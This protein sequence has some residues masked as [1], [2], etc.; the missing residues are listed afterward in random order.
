M[1]EHK[2]NEHLK[3]QSDKHFKWTTA[4][5]IITIAINASTAVYQWVTADAK[6][7]NLENKISALE[8]EIEPL[9]D[10][11]DE[12]ENILE[13]IDKSERDFNEVSESKFIATEELE[14]IENKLKDIRK[15]Y[16]IENEVLMKALSVIDR[17]GVD[18]VKG[19]YCSI[20]FP[21][22]KVSIPL[23]SDVVTINGIEYN[24]G[25][26]IGEGVLEEIIPHAGVV[27]LSEGMECSFL[28]QVPKFDELK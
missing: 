8:A 3:S 14:N 22:Y 6:V 13:A 19:Y 17:I 24:Q 23:A 18:K 2:S 28:G 26:S 21:D 16:G 9:N 4:L 15:E 25:D 7:I 1:E 10:R 12:L 20:T 27:I 5:A 11:R